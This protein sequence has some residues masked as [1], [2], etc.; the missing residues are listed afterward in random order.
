MCTYR[1]RLG[2]ISVVSC[3]AVASG[4][5]FQVEAAALS[6]RISTIPSKVLSDYYKECS[7]H[8]RLSLHSLAL[9]LTNGGVWTVRL[10]ARVIPV[11][12][13]TRLSIS[14]SCATTG[15]FVV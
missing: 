5:M 6:V 13:S 7:L 1:L 8:V 12:V 15:I 9:L 11:R 10:V 3:T 14:I 4:T 2:Q